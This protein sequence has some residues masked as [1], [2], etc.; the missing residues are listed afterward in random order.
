M[1]NPMLPA[2]LEALRPSLLRWLLL[3]RDYI[4]T[5]LSI[6]PEDFECTLFGE[7]DALG[8]A[9][10]LLGDPLPELLVELNEALAA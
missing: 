8:K 2:C 5:S 4:D 7:R 3:I 1:E 10:Q 9:H 6:G